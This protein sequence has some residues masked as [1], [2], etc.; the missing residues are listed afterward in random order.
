MIVFSGGGPGLLAVMATITKQSPEGTALTLPLYHPVAPAAEDAITRALL[1][2]D[3]NTQNRELNKTHLPINN[4]FKKPT[5]T[6]NDLHKYITNFQ[7]Q[8]KNS[9]P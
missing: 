2:E 7:F 8:I 4:Y 6:C 3:L 1:Y 9:D 5:I